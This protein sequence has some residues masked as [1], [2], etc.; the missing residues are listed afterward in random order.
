MRAFTK[1]P[2]VVPAA[3]AG[4]LV[5]ELF[6]GELT[7]VRDDERARSAARRVVEGIAPRIA[8]SRVPDFRQHAGRVSEGIVG[9]NRISPRVIVRHGDVDPEHL[10]EQRERA[11]RK[12][13]GIAR[14]A[15]V[16]QTDVQVTIRAEREVAT[17]VAAIRLRDERIAIRPDQIEPAAKVRQRDFARRS[18]KARDDGVS[19]EANVVDEQTAAARVVGRE[20]HAEQA[21]FSTLAD[22]AREIEVVVVLQDAVDHD[23]D[24]AT[25]LGDVLDVR[26]RGI[27]HE[28]NGPTESG[29]EQLGVNALRER[30][31]AGGEE[32]GKKEN[33]QT[34]TSGQ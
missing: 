32:N 6:P 8:E 27:L 23:A 13:I 31:D 12:A 15:A 19:L 3:G 18:R 1:A 10:A 26:L 9:R 20:G 16:A 33:G 14:A 17:V 21:D 34:R 11:L 2:A 24:A 5:V 4:R 7:D 29:N 22:D 25:L 28:R 30:R